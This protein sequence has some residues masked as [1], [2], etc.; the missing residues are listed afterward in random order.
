MLTCSLCLLLALASVARALRVVSP[1]KNT[2]VTCGEQ[3]SIT[4]A[5]EA[6]DEFVKKA[7]SFVRVRWLPNDW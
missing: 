1:A 2:R 6:D 4:V 7:E 3:L 5:Y